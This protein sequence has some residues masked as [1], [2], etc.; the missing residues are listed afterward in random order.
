M[1]KRQAFHYL[2]NE[3]P[4]CHINHCWFESFLL[5]LIEMLFNYETSPVVSTVRL[6]N[7]FSTVKLPSVKLYSFC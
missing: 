4:L 1:F 7:F 5:A 2:L 6:F 3:K